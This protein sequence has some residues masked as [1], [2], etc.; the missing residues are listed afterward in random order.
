M[1]KGEIDSYKQAG[2]IAKEV[3]EYAKSFVK[4]DM[5]LLEIAEKIDAKILELGGKPGF[6]VNLS[7]NEI[8]AHYTPNSEDKTIAQGLLKID[9]GVEVDGYI[10]DTA[11][12]L[13]LTENKEFQKMIDLNQ[14]ALEKALEI[15]KPRTKA[16]EIGKAI[17]ETIKDTK[18]SIIRN[19]SG[20]SLGQYKVHAGLTIS[21]YENNNETELDDVTIAIEPFLTPGLGEI[22]E[23][24]QG[25]IYSFQKSGSLRDKDAREL[26]KFIQSE[27]QTKPFC[28]RWLENQN[29]KKINHSLKVMTEQGILHN[30][31]VLIE[32]SKQPVSQA[33]HTVLI[34][35]GKVE[36]ITR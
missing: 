28:K 7:L 27:Y 34:A 6:P 13:D 26:L 21:N 5:L 22:Y 11:F 15:I 8:A 25:E 23:G 2:K 32:K 9:F 12:S 33:E 14:E 36:V 20:H 16:N 18:F 35:D 24:P 3:S 10:A 17:Q 19:L 30:Y 29:F 4:P 31:P 1:E